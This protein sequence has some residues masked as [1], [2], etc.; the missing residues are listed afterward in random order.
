[1]L[2]L[3]PYLLAVAG[4]AAL[5]AMVVRAI[6]ARGAA[7]G[8]KLSGLN[9]PK[10]NSA[11]L[12]R[13]RA[14][15]DTCVDSIYM[16]D[17][18]TLKFVDA[19]ATASS[20][21]GYSHEE[22]M[23]MGPLDLLKESREELIR[24]YDAAIAAG[25]QGI[26]TESAGRLK[27]GRESFVELNRRAVQLDGR[28]II[29]TIS[30]D[31]TER[32]RAELAAQRFARMFAALSD[33]NESIMRVF[34]ADDLFQRV[35]EAAVHGGRLKA[36]SICVPHETSGDAK[37]VAAAG[38]GADALRD[39]QISID[40]ST[41]VG[42]GLVGTAFRTQA[43]CISNDFQNDSRTAHWHEAARQAGIAAGVA[44]PLVQD[45][46]TMGILL[47]HSADK[48]AFEDEIVQLLMHMGRNVVFALDN[49][50]REAERKIAEEELHAADARL[51]RATRGAND[52][53]WEL[54]VASREMW[55]SEH[56]A[57]MFGYEQQEFLGARQKFFDILLAE[58]G[59]RLREAIERSIRD[60]VLVD[61]EVRAKTR[62][63]EAATLACEIAHQVHGAIG[64]TKEYALQLATRRLWSW[65]EEFGGDPEWAAK[66]GTYACRRGADELWPMLTDG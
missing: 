7:G 38:E 8:F 51:K 56:F 60:G 21:T 5:G 40:S 6:S 29:V 3:W 23:R 33:T 50:K 52:G 20:R 54:D 46:R 9:L 36:A 10:Q 43:P 47:L 65:R 2:E 61:V 42:R 63:G 27:D 41:A 18:E 48:N 22:L 37:V 44:L 53:L 39:A 13:F 64:F 1:M 55:V 34:S 32:K 45:G 24:S 59:V 31:V 28:W 26:R 12:R 35:C 25:A 4:G 62:V 17:R 30:R 11:E 19:T 14:I 57:E 66:V 58:D 16:V 49:F 15:V